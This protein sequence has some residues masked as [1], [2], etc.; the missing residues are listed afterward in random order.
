MHDDL[1]GNREKRQEGKEDR[2]GMRGGEV[3]SGR[4]ARK[5]SVGTKALLCCGNIK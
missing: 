3:N 1:E 5:G 4:E 2:D